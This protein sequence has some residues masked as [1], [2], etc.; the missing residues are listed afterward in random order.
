MQQDR[1]SVYY[2]L[3]KEEFK[4]DLESWKITYVE[5]CDDNVYKIWMELIL[6]DRYCPNSSKIRIVYSKVNPY[7]L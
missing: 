4:K 1:A 5:L 3:T 2:I 7:D 6:K